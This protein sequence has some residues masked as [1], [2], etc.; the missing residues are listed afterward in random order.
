MRCDSN[1]N[2]LMIAANPCRTTRCCREQPGERSGPT[3]QRRP[4][5]LVGECPDQ[6]FELLKTRPYDNQPLFY[7]P[8]FQKQ[9]IG[10]SP[11]IHWITAETVDS[12]SGIGDDLA[13]LNKPRRL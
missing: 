4:Q 12:F 10:N 3:F 6:V 2:R 13:V 7:P 8:F 5:L 1:G 11:F 9:Q